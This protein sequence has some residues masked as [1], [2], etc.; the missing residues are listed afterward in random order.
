MLHAHHTLLHIN[1]ISGKRG[2]LGQFKR[3]R[4]LLCV[5]SKCK[6]LLEKLKQEQQSALRTNTYQ[7]TVRALTCCEVHGSRGRQGGV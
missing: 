3:L 6:Q 2:P 4:C 1:G 5:H 7:T